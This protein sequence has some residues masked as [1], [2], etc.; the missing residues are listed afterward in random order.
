MDE[1]F[2]CA[3]EGDCP[4]WGK[5]G[6]A[7]TGLRRLQP[8]SPMYKVRLARRKRLAAQDYNAHYS[9]S[10]RLFYRDFVAKSQGRVM[11]YDGP[12]GCWLYPWRA[13]TPPNNS[14]GG[15]SN[16]A[17]ARCAVLVSQRRGDLSDGSRAECSH[18]CKN[19]R[20]F[21]PEH[22]VIESQRVNLSRNG[23]C[24]YVWLSNSNTLCE[25][26]DCKHTPRCLNRCTIEA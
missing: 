15:V 5:D 11:E 3:W 26:K 10:D 7:Y 17:M 19:H 23:C 6:E 13:T 20:C 16:L 21:N 4:R 8:G 24:G 22:L 9:K 2:Y 1:F 14:F 25:T 12:L 18:L